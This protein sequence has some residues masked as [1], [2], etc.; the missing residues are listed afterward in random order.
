MDIS[1]TSTSVSAYSS[2]EVAALQHPKKHADIGRIGHEHKHH[3]K[4]DEHRALGAFRQELRLR[5]KLEFNAR[6]SVRQEGYAS[7]E[8]P[9]TSDDIAADALQTAK[10]LTAESPTTAANSLVCLKAKVHETATCVRNMVGSSDD[11]SKV[12]DAV[13]KVD[14]GIAELENEVANN[15]ES[16]ASVLEVDTSSK[17]RSTV[18]IRTQE[19]DVVKLTLKRSDSLSATDRAQTDGENTATSTEVSVSSK[20]RMILKVEGDLN[21]SELAAIQNVLAQAEQIATNF[22][23]GDLG[24]AIASA[25]GFDFDIEQLARVNMRFR[26]QQKT[27]ISY[28]ESTN[29]PQIDANSAP[30]ASAATSAPAAAEAAPVVTAEPVL[31]EEATVDTLAEPVTAET[32]AQMNPT[33][34]NGLSSFFE[35]VG[36]FLR[37]VG[38]GFSQNS[39]NQSLRF[40]YSESFKLDLLRAVVH[41]AAPEA[42]DDVATTAESMIDQL[43]EVA[44]E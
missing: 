11:V 10:Q 31:A 2:S 30:A 28:R 21:E 20:S 1:T 44:A 8:G 6:F 3:Q 29:A 32:P 37:A 40:H 26:M 24:A 5:L 33:Y 13:A 12:D 14:A 35:T 43:L 38:D 27:E 7:L 17:H 42:S 18:R 25:E 23:G 19:G 34:S 39:G 9:P 4:D 15:R 22:F 36:N 41:T 16:S